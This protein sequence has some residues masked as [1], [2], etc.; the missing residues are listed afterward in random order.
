MADLVDDD[1]PV[2]AESGELFGEVSSPLGVGER[3]TQSVAVAN[4]TR[5][6]WRAA[7]TPRA[8]ARWVCRCRAGRGARRCRVNVVR[9]GI[10]DTPML[11][12]MAGDRRDPG[13]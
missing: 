2:A 9:P 12:R 4:S 13:C 8:V 3:V 7:V 11:A 6:P 5:C 10:V 1:Q